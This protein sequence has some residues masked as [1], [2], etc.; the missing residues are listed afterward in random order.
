LLI[1]SSLFRDRF[2]FISGC[3]DLEAYLV[4]R[5][6]PYE[7]PGVTANRLL[8]FPSLDAG[9]FLIRSKSPCFSVH[10][11][12][13]FFSALPLASYY[14]METATLLLIPRLQRRTSPVI[15]YAAHVGPYTLFS[16]CVSFECFQTPFFV[17]PS[18]AWSIFFFVFSPYHDF[19]SK[20]LVEFLP[21]S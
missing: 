21:P 2:A 15:P 19:T 8:Q 17:A 1:L 12:T 3:H 11:R 16:V 10:E 5:S 18:P 7:L 9:Y 20:F 4:F 6:F 13:H 14:A